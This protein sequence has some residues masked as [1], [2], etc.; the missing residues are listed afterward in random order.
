LVIE[1]LM[2]VL[3]KLISKGELGAVGRRE[4]NGFVCEWTSQWGQNLSVR[5]HSPIN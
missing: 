3:R 1:E 2:D 5:L 4:I